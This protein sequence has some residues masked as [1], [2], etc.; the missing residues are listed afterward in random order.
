VAWVF[1]IHERE[2]GVFGSATAGKHLLVQRGAEL[3]VTGRSEVQAV[4]MGFA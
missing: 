1:S 2:P 4:C 3:L